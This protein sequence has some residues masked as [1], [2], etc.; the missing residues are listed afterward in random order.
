MVGRIAQVLLAVLIAGCVPATMFD[1]IGYFN[2]APRL[3]YQGFSFDR[4]PNP[5]W[6]LLQS[7]QSHTDVTLRRD[8]WRPS[9]T[10]SFYARVSLGEIESQ[11]QTHDEFAELARSKGQE[12]PYEVR[13]I[14]YE[15][16]LT[17]R[18]NQ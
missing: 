8:F 12:A 7:E 14:A 10:H 5:N 17:T 3:E 9:E 13:T 1:K 11:P 16:R 15:Q 4:P 18:Q 6:Y 2:M